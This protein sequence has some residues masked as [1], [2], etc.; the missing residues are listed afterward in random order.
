L[1]QADKWISMAS[2]C[3]RNKTRDLKISL[4]LAFIPTPFPLPW[5]I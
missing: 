1:T 2:Y 3:S 4:D 5:F